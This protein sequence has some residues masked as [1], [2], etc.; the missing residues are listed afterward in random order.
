MLV[1]HCEHARPVTVCTGG[2][3][4][5]V[6]PQRVQKDLPAGTAVAHFGHGVVAKACAWDVADAPALTVAPQRVQKRSAAFK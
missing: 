2:V 5:S 3:D 6:V 1:P 4:L